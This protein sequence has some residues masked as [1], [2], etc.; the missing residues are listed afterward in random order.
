[1]ILL[2]AQ[3]EQDRQRL[4]DDLA[5]YIKRGGSVEHINGYVARNDHLIGIMPMDKI[6]QMRTGGKRGAKTRKDK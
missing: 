3:K 6:A 2:N 5:A 1:M 4:A